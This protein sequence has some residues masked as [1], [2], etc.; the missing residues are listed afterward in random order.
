[1]CLSHLPRTSNFTTSPLLQLSCTI[2][3]HMHLFFLNQFS[4]TLR[5]WPVGGLTYHVSRLIDHRSSRTVAT[6]TPTNTSYN[7]C[8]SRIDKMARGDV[9]KAKSKKKGHDGNGVKKYTGTR[10]TT[11]STTRL[12][13]SYVPFSS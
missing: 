3:T 1:M 11:R 12:N 9:A 2:P 7:D 6:L 4:P 5:M 13:Q 10:M 8:T